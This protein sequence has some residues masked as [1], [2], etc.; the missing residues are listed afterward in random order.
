MTLKSTPIICASVAANPSPLGVALHN[1]GYAKL[2][3]D[4]TYVALGGDTISEALEFMKICGGRGLGVSMPHKQS[5]IQLLD[6][7][8]KDV[9]TIGACNTVVFTTNGT[10]TGHNTDWIGA[11]DSIHES[12]YLPR[13][14]VIIGAGGVARAI[15]YA[16]RTLDVQV[17]IRARNID[18]ARSLVADLELEGA[19]PLDHSAM[20][21][22]DLVVNATPCIEPSHPVSF[23]EYPNAQALFDVVFSSLETPLVREALDRG[24][25]IVPGWRMLLHQALEQFRL[26]TECEPPIDEMGD[27]LKRAFG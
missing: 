1:A 16:L 23:D 8:T 15:A 22:I 14:A 4:Y 11:R 27:V 10:T 2:G 26:Y 5:V 24:L 13:R 21:N 19:L 9:E 6:N 18:A 17:F 25:V 12:G 20:A 3:L 7:V